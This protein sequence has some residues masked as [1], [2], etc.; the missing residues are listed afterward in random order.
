LVLRF[1]ANDDDTL[2]GIRSLFE[3]KLKELGAL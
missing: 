1:E 3:D 2:K